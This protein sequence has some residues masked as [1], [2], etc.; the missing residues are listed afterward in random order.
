MK[1]AETRA[2]E[3]AT[4]G[5]KKKENTHLHETLIRSYSKGELAY[6]YNPD[7]SDSAARRRFSQWMHHAPTLMQNL[8]DTGY[9]ESQR[10][11]TP[12]QVAL[13]FEALGEP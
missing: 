3:T 12:R 7:I 5:S 4:K 8:F 1:E 2:A 11:F 10:T 13:I 9:T 6:M